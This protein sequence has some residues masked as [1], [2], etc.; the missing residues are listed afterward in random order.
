MF[1]HEGN[2]VLKEIY[3]PYILGKKRPLRGKIP[4]GDAYVA[5][6]R[7]HLDF[8]NY[9]MLDRMRGG[10]CAGSDA[11]LAQDITDM[12]LGGFFRNY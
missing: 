11:E 6:T 2:H 12:D 7:L 10:L 4:R 5:P 8:R 3:A 1:A 9:A